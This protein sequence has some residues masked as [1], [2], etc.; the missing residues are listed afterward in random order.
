MTTSCLSRWELRGTAEHLT[1]QALLSP[2]V[3]LLLDAQTRSLLQ[4][5]GYLSFLLGLSLAPRVQ[6]VFIQQPLLRLIVSLARRVPISRVQNPAV[7]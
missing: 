6:P 1:Q 3:Q 7:V 5:V 2:Q 4:A